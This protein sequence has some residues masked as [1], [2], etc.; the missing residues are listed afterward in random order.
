[1]RDLIDAHEV[2]NEVLMTR[3]QYS[4]CFLIVE[5]QASDLYG[6]TGTS[7]IKKHAR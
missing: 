2:A 1:M 3:E 5:G 7:L 6:Y 4:G